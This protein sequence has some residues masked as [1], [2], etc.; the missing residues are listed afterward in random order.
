MNQTL[1]VLVISWSLLLSS[2]SSAAEK[3]QVVEVRLTDYAFNPKTFNL[4]PGKIQF[5]VKNEGTDLHSF[6]IEWKTGG[7]TY[8]VATPELN[9]GEKAGLLVELPPGEY[10]VYCYEEQHREQGMEGRMTI[11]K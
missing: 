9:A 2:A 7:K 3:L 1:S 10:E 8:S 6:R 4:K 5:N 11:G